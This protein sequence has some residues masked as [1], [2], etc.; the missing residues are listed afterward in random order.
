[1]ENVETLLG[2]Q[3]RTATGQE[4]QVRGTFE[5][6][7]TIGLSSF[8]HVFLVADIMDEIILGLD[9]MIRNNF[10]INLKEKSLK[11]L[12]T[13]IPLRVG[14]N[15]STYLPTAQKLVV[16][17]QT[18]IPPNSENVI[19]VKTSQAVNNE[20]LVVAESYSSSSLS[21]ISIKGTLLRIGKDNLFPVAILN[22]SNSMKIIKKGTI[23]AQCSE[24][25]A[26]VTKDIRLEGEN[27]FLTV[28]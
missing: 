26:V 10:T 15:N 5:A 21:D 20:L 14:E 2:I 16:T 25:K 9:F 7:I 11:F 28:L 24:V 22:T 23:V 4:A 1:M 19:W 27:P 17:R 13:E 12:N 3:L 8:S 6:I 18:K